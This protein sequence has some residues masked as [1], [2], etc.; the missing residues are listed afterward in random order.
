[1]KDLTWYFKNPISVEKFSFGDQKRFSEEH[2]GRLTAQNTN[3]QYSTMLTDT[4]QK[5]TDYFGDIT[6][7][8][9]K[10][11]VQQSQ[12]QIVDDCIE[13]FKKR[14]SRLNNSL[15]AQGYEKMPF[16]QTFFP[17]GVTEFT[18]DTNKTNFESNI[19]RII[20]ALNAHPNESGGASVVQ[21]FEGL[22]TN[23]TAAR[24]AQLITKGEAEG[25]S[26]VRDEKGIIWADQV[27]SNLLTIALAHRNQPEIIN[28]FFDQSIL[29]TISR[30]DSDGKG[31][32]TGIVKDANT[33]EPIADVK[34]H[35]IDGK[36][37]DTTTQKEGTYRTGK[38]A[39]GIYTVTFS[40]E[41]YRSQSLSITIEDEGDT[42]QD[43]LLEV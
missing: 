33:N 18:R 30:E 1:M 21:E 17:F 11:A 6:D 9:I 12:T 39:V 20:A 38:L 36:I 16:Y 3:G 8:K 43:I 31:R 41:G 32:L 29:R 37:N 40:K 13:A 23:Y 4:V 26:T 25:K 34:I 15:L 10:K 42:A 14:V 19:N 2:I 5:H 35:I 27:F 22:R 7:V 28:D 24:K